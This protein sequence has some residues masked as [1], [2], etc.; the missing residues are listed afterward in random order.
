MGSIVSRL[1][2]S[3]DVVYLLA[4]ISLLCGGLAAFFVHAEVSGWEHID[5]AL[6]MCSVFA[7]T[8]VVC[9]ILFARREWL[10]YVFLMVFFAMAAVMMVIW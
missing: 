1:D 9:G 8:A 10:P 5:G 4:C 7:V 3:I 6:V 2:S